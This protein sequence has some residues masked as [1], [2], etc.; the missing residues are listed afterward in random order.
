MVFSFTYLSHSPLS[1]T[2]PTMSTRKPS[3][4]ESEQC[5]IMIKFKRLYLFSTVLTILKFIWEALW[6]PVWCSCSWWIVIVP[7]VVMIELNG[8]DASFVV[9]NTA[10]TILFRRSKFQLLLSSQ[11][12]PSL[13]HLAMICRKERY[14]YESIQ[15]SRVSQHSTQH[16]IRELRTIQS[17]LYRHWRGE[18]RFTKDLAT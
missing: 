16:W 17:R 9:K 18:G 4:S 3:E 6:Y 1:H 8:L 11:S 2:G 5:P 7:I 15:C 10:K 14:S 12:Q 13:S